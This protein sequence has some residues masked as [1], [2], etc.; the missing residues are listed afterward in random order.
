VYDGL[1]AGG[2]GHGPAAEPEW[3]PVAAADDAEVEPSEETL[4]DAGLP[5]PA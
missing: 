4:P 1:A 5:A 3:I 2:N